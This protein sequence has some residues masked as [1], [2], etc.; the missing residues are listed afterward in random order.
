MVKADPSS[1]IQ[2]LLKDNWEQIS[3]LVPQ[4]MTSARLFQMSVNAINHTPELLEASPETLLSCV[5]KCAALG[6]EPS[7]VDGLGN[8]YILPYRNHGRMEAQFIL[9]YTGMLRLIRNSGQIESI[10]AR[11]VRE[12][13]VFEF[14]YGLDEKLRHVPSLSSNGE[15]THVYC[16]AKFKDGGHYMEVMTKDEVDA[17]K[18]RSRASKNGPWVTDYE[19]MARKTVIRRS[20]KYLPVSVAAQE[21]VAADEMTPDYSD[22]FKP[23]IKVESEVEQPV[24]PAQPTD[25]EKAELRDLTNRCAAVGLGERES[26]QKLYAQWKQGGIEAARA[27]ADMNINGVLHQGFDP[28]TGEVFDEMDLADEDI[29][30]GEE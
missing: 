2:M 29:P 17:V 25:E 20:F 1:G 11:V 10:E 7:A 13:D 12:G 15:I 18:K 24:Q 28:E 26:A 19:A 4:H 8:C 3:A 6:L 22:V 27:L 23:V 14:E 21:A 30:F 5:M 16:L 9:G